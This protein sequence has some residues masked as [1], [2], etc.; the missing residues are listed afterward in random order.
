MIR[1][2]AAAAMT[3]VL[4]GATAPMASATEARQA[5]AVEQKAAVVALGTSAS[6]LGAPR[7]VEEGLDERLAALPADRTMEQALEA[8]YPGDPVAQRAVLAVLNGQA[9]PAAPRTEG[10]AA[11]AD[12]PMMAASGWGTAWKYTKCVAYVAAVFVPGATGFKA[13]K[14]LGGVKTTAKLLVKAG[15]ADDFLKIAGGAAAEIIGINGIRDN[16]F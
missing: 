10:R 7:I 5:R 6:D 9:E 16:C 2:G 15:N 13:I 12:G 8:M 14:A 3:A 4:L 1:L 11:S